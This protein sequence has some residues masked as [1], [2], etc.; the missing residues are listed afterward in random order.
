MEVGDD[1]S[2]RQ[3]RSKICV[4]RHGAAGGAHRRSYAAVISTCAIS[5]RSVNLC[6]T[7]IIRPFTW[8]RWGKRASTVS[9]AILSPVDEL[10]IGVEHDDHAGVV[11]TAPD[12]TAGHATC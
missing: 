6:G 9:R 7:V 1:P 8:S 5:T 11:I 2:L 3:R 12:G 10:E 4:E